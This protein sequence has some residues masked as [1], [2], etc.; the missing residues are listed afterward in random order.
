MDR[1][2]KP[3]DLAS[4]KRTQISALALSLWRKHKGD[5]KAK[6]SDAIGEVSR[7]VD[8]AC[9]E[10]HE[11]RSRRSIS[12]LKPDQTSYATKTPAGKDTNKNLR[13]RG[14]RGGKRKVNKRNKKDDSSG[15]SVTFDAEPALTS[16]E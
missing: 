16:E 14:S 3:A 1:V 15:L 5:W 7:A 9:R 12:S 13:K 4:E 2:F 10:L 8:R 6:K 11:E